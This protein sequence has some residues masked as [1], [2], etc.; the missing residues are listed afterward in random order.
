MSLGDRLYRLALR[1]YPAD[2]RRERGAE[3]LTTIS[4]GGDGFRARELW[5]LVVGGLGQRGR[6]ARADSRAGTWAGGAQLGALVVLLVTAAASLYP[7]VW[8][9]WYVR[10]GLRWPLDL[11]GVTMPPA[12]SN[13]LA[14]QAMLFVTSLLAAVAVCRGRVRVALAFSVTMAT[15][16]LLG[17]PDVSVSGVGFGF[18]EA[19]SLAQFRDSLGFACQAAFYAVPTLLLWSARD[20]QSRRHTLGWLVLPFALGALSLAF[21]TSTITFWTIGIIAIAWL[22]CSRANPRLGVATIAVSISATLYLIPVVIFQPE[23]TYAGLVAIGGVMLSA[24]ALLSVLR[25][26]TS[27]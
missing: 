11:V 13:Y 14:L 16:Y 21:Y 15:L 19:R 6:F 17:F 3:I 18:V 26:R 9:V 7:L 4:D 12:P 10:L 24:A 22:L 27:A 25:P 5:A 1:A 2:Y 8:E 20:R 23:Y